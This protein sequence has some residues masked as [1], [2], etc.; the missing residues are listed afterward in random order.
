MEFGPNGI[1]PGQFL[2]YKESGI[3][4]TTECLSIKMM[5]SYEVSFQS[6]GFVQKNDDFYLRLCRF[7][8]HD[9]GLPR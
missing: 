1:W 7:K 6:V 4:L 5:E 2:L 9:L 8:V 3:E